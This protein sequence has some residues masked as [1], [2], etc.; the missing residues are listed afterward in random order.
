MIL[1]QIATSPLPS[2]TASAPRRSSLPKCSSNSSVDGTTSPGVSAMRDGDI[3]TQK[4]DI[5]SGDENLKK[6]E[7]DYIAAQPEPVTDGGCVVS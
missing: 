4:R 5:N 1:Q 2:A 3:S 6:Q 7:S